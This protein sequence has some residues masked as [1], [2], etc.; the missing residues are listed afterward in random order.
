MAKKTSSWQAPPFTASD[1]E[2]QGWVEEACIQEGES[3]LKGQSAYADI[4]KALNIISGKIADDANQ[5]RSQLNINHA[6]FDLRKIIGTLADVREA[7]QYT[8]DSKYFLKQ[9]D[10]FNKVSKAVYLESMFPR[11]LRMSLQ[12]MAATAKGYLWP[13]FERMNGEEG[14]INFEPLGLLDVLPVQ[15]PADNDLQKAYSVTA[16]VFMPVYMAHGKF[17]TFQSSL[18]P[19]ARRKYLS[20]VSARRLDLAEKFKYGE[21]SGENWANL[22]CEIRYTFI[23]DLSINEMDV[24]IPMGDFDEKGEPKTSWSYKVPVRGQLIPSHVGADGERVMRPAEPEDCM[25]Y[26]YRRLII[27]SRGMGTPMYDGPAKDWH[28]MA[29]F[30]EYCADDWPWEPSGYSLVHDIH[31][32]ERARQAVER[33]IDQVMKARLDPS[34]GYDRSQGL[35]D[36]TALTLDPFEERGRVGIDGEVRKVIDSLLP[37]WLMEVPNSAEI[38][39]KYLRDAEDAQL[40]LNEIQ[41]LA[42][43]KAN[44]T[45]ENSMEKALSLVG[46]LVKDI[47]S[48]MEASTVTVWQLLKY[49]IPQYYDTKRIMQYVGPDGVSPETFDYDPASILPS[50]GHDEFA[51]MPKDQVIA[52]DSVYDK[53]QRARMF[54]KNLRLISVPHTM[55]EITQTQEQLKWLQLYRGGFPLAPHDVAKKLNIDNYGEID[56]ST[57][58]ER[59]INYKELEIEMASRLAQLA[60]ALAPPGSEMGGAPSAPGGGQSKT[61]G[62]PPSGGKS[63]K[64]KQ[65]TGGPLGAR[66]TVSESG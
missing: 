56:G 4:P 54:A 50:H 25:I 2:R 19:I 65:K 45:S 30:A 62:R 64:I 35:N 37:Q 58:W 26:P 20:T 53:I 32:I 48:G 31:S 39:V 11:R 6:K 41:N 66:T 49:M 38:F 24:E 22:Y 1:A 17:P 14:R 52:K 27:T 42:E 28:G 33:G 9:A 40:G 57:Y 51:N 12:Y 3:W 29:P 43:F 15:M 46:P 63:P 7:A 34:L 13:K 10:M 55:H 36:S 5:K 60:Q 44:L 47:A 18:L 59:Y 16:I 61:G 8:S 23:R 21:S